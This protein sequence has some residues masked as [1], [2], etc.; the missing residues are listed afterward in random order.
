[1]HSAGYL[2]MRSGDLSEHIGKHIG[3]F[4]GVHGGYGIGQ[5]S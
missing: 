1:M 3:G 5:R 4:Y 2:V